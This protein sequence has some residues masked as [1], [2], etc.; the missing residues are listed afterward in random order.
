LKVLLKIHFKAFYGLK[1]SKGALCIKAKKQKKKNF[2][3]NVFSKSF[4]TNPDSHQS[5]R[6]TVPG[7]KLLLRKLFFCVHIWIK[8]W[9][10]FFFKLSCHLKENHCHLGYCG[11]Q[12][13]LSL[14]S[15]IPLFAGKKLKALLNP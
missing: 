4:E 9:Q 8:A 5:S 2:F 12:Y 11:C 15:Q 10:Q 6:A 13:S 7:L 3:G 1:I 14:P